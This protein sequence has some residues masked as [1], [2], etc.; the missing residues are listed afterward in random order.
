MIHTIKLDT[1]SELIDFFKYSAVKPVLV[2]AHRGGR[3]LCFPEN[4]IATFENTLQYT[5]SIFEVDIR[6]TKDSV[7]V[8]MHDK[9]LDRT[10]TGKGNLSNYS[11]DELKEIRLKDLHGNVTDYKIP[12]LRDALSWSQSKTVLVLDNKDVPFDMIVKILKEENAFCN[13]LVIVHN[14]KEAEYFYNIDNCFMFEAYAFDK[15][16]ALEY[17]AIKIPWSH[18]IIQKMNLFIEK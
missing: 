16:A 5:A 15:K 18:I 14:A 9:T 13:T 3:R 8:L 17:D 2:S 12:S 11:W 4:C 6:L 7:V 1:H 10:T